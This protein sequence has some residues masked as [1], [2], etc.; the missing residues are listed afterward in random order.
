LDEK[1]VT[2]R[3]KPIERHSALVNE[4][5]ITNDSQLLREKQ[6]EIERLRDE[7][8]ELREQKTSMERSNNLVQQNC[9][10]KVNEQKRKILMNR[11]EQQVMSA[12]IHELGARVAY[13]NLTGQNV[14]EEK[15]IEKN[16]FF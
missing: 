10:L 8:F 13:K 11:K 3:A 5:E 1:R 4:N 9:E 2:Q 16:S 15:S 14:Q 12:L 6:I 7:N